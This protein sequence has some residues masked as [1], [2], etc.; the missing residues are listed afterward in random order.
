MIRGV[1]RLRYEERCARRDAG[2]PYTQRDASVQSSNESLNW[3]SFQADRADNILRAVFPCNK[4][5]SKQVVV[6]MEPTLDFLP[7]VTI[8]KPGTA[9]VLMPEDIYAAL[10]QRESTVARFFKDEK[11]A[12]NTDLCPEAELRKTV[13]RRFAY[14][15]KLA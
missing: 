15:K 13:R 14:F 1:R 10:M 9:G 2:R 4:S 8:C 7:S 3:D 5:F 6:A 11:I 12:A